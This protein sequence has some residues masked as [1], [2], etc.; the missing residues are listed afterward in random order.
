MLGKNDRGFGGGKRQ[1]PPL[2]VYRMAVL[3]S[4]IHILCQQIVVT[5][6]LYEVN[7]VILQCVFYS[8]IVVTLI[9]YGVNNLFFILLIIL[10][11]VVTL[12][13]YGVNNYE[14]PKVYKDGIVVTLILY[15]VNND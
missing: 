4:P 10:F 7:N 8:L 2:E 5:F 14:T 6:I 3:A 1:Q 9:L 15:G 12:I 11:I 13:L